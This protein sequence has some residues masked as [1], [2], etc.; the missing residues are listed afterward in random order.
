MAQARGQ[1]ATGFGLMILANKLVAEGHITG[2]QGQVKG[3]KLT[4]SRELKQLRKLQEL[5]L[6]LLDIMIKKNKLIN[7]ESLEDLTLWCFLWFSC[8]LSYFHRPT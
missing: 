7:I 5:F 4:T 6:M 8:R 1:L 3:E 2:V